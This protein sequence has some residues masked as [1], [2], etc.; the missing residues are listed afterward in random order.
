[1]RA[2]NRRSVLARPI[3][4][5]GLGT[6]AEF[7]IWVIPLVPSRIFWDGEKVHIGGTHVNRSENRG[8]GAVKRCEQVGTWGLFS[9]KQRFKRSP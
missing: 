4:R 7:S 1:M 6:W 5:E 8:M 9:L 2:T 3:R